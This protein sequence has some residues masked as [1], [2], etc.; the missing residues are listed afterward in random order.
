MN[1]ILDEIRFTSWLPM[2]REPTI[3]PGLGLLDPTL[4]QAL[5]GAPSAEA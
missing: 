5:L 2:N 4:T 1:V 3:V